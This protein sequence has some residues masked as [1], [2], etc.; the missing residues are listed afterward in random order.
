M[1]RYLRPPEELVQEFV[2]T[3][4][5]ETD[6]FRS[7]L[8]K[9][10]TWYAAFTQSRHEKKVSEHLSTR[11][12][13]NFLPLY[14]TVR[15]WTH[16]RKVALDLPLFPNYI[17]VYIRPEERIR[18][19]EVSGLVTLVGRGKTPEALSE[20]EIESLRSALGSRKCEPHPYLAA[21]T[22]AR[23]IAGPLAGM[24]GVVSR[25]KSGGLRAILTIDMIMQS[26]AVEVAAEE[27]E[28]DACFA[29]A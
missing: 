25:T 5:P 1:G 21:G 29:T 24:Q 11:G 6:V 14:K 18:A 7:G 22:K 27:L 28:P 12:I 19:M 10:R 23:I 26:V 17:F 4:P 16:Y 20:I 15:S 13:E 8:S 2:V 9:P 3:E